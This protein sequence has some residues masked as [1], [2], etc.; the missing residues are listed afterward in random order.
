MREAS[1]GLSDVQKEFGAG[2]VSVK[3]D[4]SWTATV[5]EPEAIKKAMQM[6][7]GVRKV[8]R[9]R[10]ER[11]RSMHDHVMLRDGNGRKVPVPVEHADRVARKRGLVEVSRRKATLRGRFVDGQYVE[12]RWVPGAGWVETE[13]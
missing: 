12:E 4:G 1:P 13:D 10:G 11:F 8:D 6:M 5:R 3:P 7:D 9:T 2:A